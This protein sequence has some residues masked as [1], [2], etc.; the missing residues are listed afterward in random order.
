MVCVLPSPKV[1]LALF[2]SMLSIL[3]C[4]S[5]I[6]RS[7]GG[8]KLLLYQC[9][10]MEASGVCCLHLR[11]Y[12]CRFYIFFKYSCVIILF[13]DQRMDEK[14]SC[15]KREEVETSGVTCRFP[16]Y[17]TPRFYIFIHILLCNFFCST[18]R[19]RTE[20]ITL[21]MQGSKRYVLP[22]LSYICVVFIYFKYFLHNSF[23]SGSQDRRK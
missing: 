2:L 14:L 11:Y 5:F 21:A 17:Y 3:L 15:Y 23:V 13:H 1:L 22:S 16:R 7:E 4:N 9:E 6:P 8:R 18:I 10:E 20:I 19:G 12:S